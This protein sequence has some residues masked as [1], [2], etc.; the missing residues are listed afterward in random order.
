VKA[1]ASTLK[2]V[3]AVK[4][5]PKGRNGNAD[6]K[7]SSHCSPDHGHAYVELSEVIRRKRDHDGKDSSVAQDTFEKR[8][9]EPKTTHPDTT[10]IESRDNTC[11]GNQITP[12]DSTSCIDDEENS[13]ALD[14][15][16]SDTYT[17][18]LDANTTSSSLPSVAIH[19][20]CE[21]LNTMIFNSEGSDGS[22]Y[23]ENWPYQE[24]L[25][26]LQDFGRPNHE[27][28]SES[29]LDSE[30]ELE[31]EKESLETH[32]QCLRGELRSA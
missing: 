28:D 25:E 20:A 10:A 2:K 4:S 19:V 31:Y 5:S 32:I 27:I 29:D 21:K 26:Q 9:K 17:S 30:S 15:L 1:N 18:M 16:A 22:A 13:V 8:D 6:R 11:L 24:Q 23:N 3:T 12:S 7:T 14:D